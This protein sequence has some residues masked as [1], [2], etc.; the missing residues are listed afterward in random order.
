MIS[1][2]VYGVGLNIEINRAI[3]E[4][5]K[6]ATIANRQREIALYKARGY[7]EVVVRRAGGGGARV[8]DPVSVEA[9]VEFRV[10][11]K[12]LWMV[13]VGDFEAEVV[14]ENANEKGKV[15]AKNRR[16][17]GGGVVS[18]LNI[19]E[20]GRVSRRTNLGVIF[21]AVMEVVIGNF[22]VVKMLT[23]SVRGNV[24]HFLE[25]GR[26]GWTELVFVFRG[27]VDIAGDVFAGY[28]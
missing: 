11:A 3:T 18:K 8:D 21:A 12:R 23:E 28:D 24:G 20:R 13:G 22:F 17:F 25:V 6:F 15:I 19:V 16:S 14:V 27:P 26:D 1:R 7:K 2:G 10:Q 5:G 9:M 4:N